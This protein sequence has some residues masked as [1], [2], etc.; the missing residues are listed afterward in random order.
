MFKL[1]FYMSTDTDECEN[2]IDNNC[3]DIRGFCNNTIGSFS[4]S[5]RTGYSGDGTEGNCD[6]M[7]K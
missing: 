6:G 7:N 3:D 5:C 2:L 4:C 1:A